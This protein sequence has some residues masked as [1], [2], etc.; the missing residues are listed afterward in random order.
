M[1]CEAEWLFMLLMLISMYSGRTKVLLSV[2][3]L[4]RVLSWCLHVQ[5]WCN[6]YRS[7]MLGLQ[8]YASSTSALD[9]AWLRLSGKHSIAERHAVTMGLCFSLVGCCDCWC[10][11]KLVAEQLQRLHGGNAWRRR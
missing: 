4:S 7:D 11:H 1:V 5:L 6:V 3:A 9:P 10:V 8:G 2:V